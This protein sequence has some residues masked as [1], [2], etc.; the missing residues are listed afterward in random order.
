MNELKVFNFENNSVR[1]Q[2]DEAGNPWFVAKDVC[3]VLG[4]SKNRDAVARLR[5]SV[6]R[7]VIVDGVEMT[8]LSEPG[9]YQMILKSKKLYA[10]RFQDWV[11]N[12]VLPSIRK[13][14]AYFR[15]ELTLDERVMLALEVGA[16]TRKQLSEVKTAISEVRQLAIQASSHNSAN[17]GFMTIRGY[18]NVHSIKLSLKDSQKIGRA[19]SSLARSHGAETR[20]TDDEM[21]G[22][23]KAYPIGILDEVFKQLAV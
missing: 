5:G 13:T 23:V 9:F 20:K 4:I 18:T 1:T 14:G 3:D 6:T 17:T 21:F 11:T 2:I 12:E 19:A 10:G 16:D 7:P 8:V 22:A 15:K